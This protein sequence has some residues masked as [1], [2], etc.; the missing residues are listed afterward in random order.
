MTLLRGVL[1]VLLWPVRMIAAI[2]Q[3][4][5]WSPWIAVSLHAL[6]VATTIPVILELPWHWTVTPALALS[7]AMNVVGAVLN[8][9]LGRRV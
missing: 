4:L 5:A 3:L 6:A 8:F 7:I 9:Q 2:V 1:W